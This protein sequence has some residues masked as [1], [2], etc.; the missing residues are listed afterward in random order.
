MD[1]VLDRSLDEIL[2]ERGPQ[3]RSD[4]GSLTFGTQ[5]TDANGYRAV[6]ETAVLAEEAVVP[7]ASNKSTRAM[8]SERYALPPPPRPRWLR[9]GA[10]SM[11]DIASLDVA[12]G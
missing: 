3:V 1:Q 10:E 8:A 4:D 11:P 12:T 5:E 9:W 6:V 2:E 7:V